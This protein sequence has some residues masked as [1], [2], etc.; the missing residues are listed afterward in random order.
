M[1]T[2]FSHFVDNDIYLPTITEKLIDI[3]IR[4]CLLSFLFTLVPPW[5]L[6]SFPMVKMD[7]SEYI[8]SE[9]EKWNG[10]RLQ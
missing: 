5:P 1:T 6:L 10:K 8:A 3:V 9:N 4:V 7:S 2:S